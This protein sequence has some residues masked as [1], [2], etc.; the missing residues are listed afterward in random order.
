MDAA[1]G[2]TRRASDQSGSSHHNCFILL[3]SDGLLGNVCQDTFSCEKKCRSPNQQK[4][5][6]NL[7]SD[8]AAV[9]TSVQQV[10]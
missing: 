9:T 2:Q 6:I 10:I 3:T 4:L 1:E 7:I 5:L 8:H